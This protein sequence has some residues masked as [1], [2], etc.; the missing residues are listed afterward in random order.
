[1]VHLNT[2][3]VKERIGML[4]LSDTFDV[5]DPATGAQVG[6]CLEEPPTWVK[7]LKL[8]VNKI[9]LPTTIRICDGV[10]A[11]SQTRAILRKGF[12][13]IGGMARVE[14]SAGRHL[15]TLKRAGWSFKR[16]FKILG[17]D[18]AEIAQV[19]GDWKGW[20]FTVTDPQNVTI[21]TITKKWAGL[22]R[23]MFTSADNYVVNVEGAA[24]GKPD[25]KLLILCTALAIDTIFKEKG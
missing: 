14:D 23:E 9:L 2:F 19:Q 24:I 15:G 11:H 22:G 12:V 6:I 18:E 17:P 21:G 8:V 20:N 25:L 13:F 1:M 3:L 10:D 4:R 7:F 16:Y 5:F